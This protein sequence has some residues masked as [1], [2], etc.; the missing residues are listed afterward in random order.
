MVRVGSSK[1]LACFSIVSVAGTPQKFGKSSPPSRV[2]HT[3]G[4]TAQLRDEREGG[5]HTLWRES[6][7]FLSP[8][9]PEPVT[10]QIKKRGMKMNTAPAV[11]RT[12]RASAL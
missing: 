1:N 12:D 10:S 6:F 9:P 11:R 2:A 4:S 3:W 8:F 7:F 5:K